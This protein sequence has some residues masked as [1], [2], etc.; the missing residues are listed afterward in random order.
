MKLEI[1]I[2]DADAAALVENVWGRKTVEEIVR[3]MVEDVGAEYRR[4]FPSEAAGSDYS[5]AS[6]VD[7]AP[8]R[9]K[10]AENINLSLSNR[11]GEIMIG[12]G[13]DGR[14]YLIAEANTHHDTEVFEGLGSTQHIE[15][16]EAAFL[17]L[18]NAGHLAPPTQDSNEANQ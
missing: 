16:S 6:E 8:I 4:K 9:V 17:S 7:T 15:I 5:P 2:S 18:A 12:K 11:D 1:E 10:L 3:R 13:V 14:C